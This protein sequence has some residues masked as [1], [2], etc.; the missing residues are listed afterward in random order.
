MESGDKKKSV[1]LSLAVII[2]SFIFWFLKWVLK[3]FNVWL[4]EY[5]LPEKVRKRL[6]PG[7]LGWPL[8]GN[9]WDFLRAFKSACPDSFTDSYV[10]RFVL[11]FFYWLSKLILRF[12]VPFLI[13]F[14]LKPNYKFENLSET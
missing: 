12:V 11:C 8:I 3:K 7:D 1:E 4:Y 9:L 6:P 10:S 2:I 14:L 13:C 5:T